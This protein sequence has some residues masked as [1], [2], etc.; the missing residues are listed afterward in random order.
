MID[1]RKGDVFCSD[2][3]GAK[4][5]ALIKGVQAFWSKDGEAKYAHSGIFASCEE[6]FEALW[7]VRKQNFLDTYSGSNVLIARPL[8]PVSLKVAVVDEMI[9]EYIG[10]KYPWW[11]LLLHLFPP[12]ARI[13]LL[14][15]PVC[16]ELT[17]DYLRRIG[18]R[19][20]H[21]AGTTPDYLADEWV[22]WKRFDVIFSGK[23]IKK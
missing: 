19:P 11:R 20:Y 8:A 14:K 22:Q 17:A 5:G 10:E 13:S 18:V 15:R 16:S 6:T 3:P 12:A 21:W 9:E 2:H 4:L 1:I 7:T 23:V